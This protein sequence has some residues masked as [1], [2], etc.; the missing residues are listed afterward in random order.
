M[1]KPELADL[2]LAIIVTAAIAIAAVFYCLAP[3]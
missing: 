1:R 2:A 3:W